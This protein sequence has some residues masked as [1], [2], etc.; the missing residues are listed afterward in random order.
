MTEYST[1]LLEQLS[2]QMKNVDIN[3]ITLGT[4]VSLDRLAMLEKNLVNWNGPVSLAIFVPVKTLASGL[5]DW[6]RYSL[7]IH[8]TFATSLIQN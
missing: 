8:F 3:Q 4:H 7:M 5:D 1:V 6:Q 2:Y